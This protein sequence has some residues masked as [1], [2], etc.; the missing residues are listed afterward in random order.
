MSIKFSFANS[1]CLCPGAKVSLLLPKRPTPPSFT[2][3]PPPPPLPP[4]L[5]SPKAHGRSPGGG[6]RQKHGGSDGRDAIGEVL[7]GPILLK[8]LISVTGL[9]AQVCFSHPLLMS[10]D[11][12]T[13]L[14]VFVEELFPS[15][16]SKL[17]TNSDSF[18][19]AYSS[20]S[21]A[22]LRQRHSA[23]IRHGI[24]HRKQAGLA[25]AKSKEAPQQGSMS[26]TLHAVS[27]RVSK[28]DMSLLLRCAEV[29]DFVTVLVLCACRFSVE[30]GEYAQLPPS[31][32]CLVDGG[33]GDHRG[34]VSCAKQ[35]DSLE[36]LC[37]I[38]SLQSGRYD[39]TV[40]VQ[41]MY[42]LF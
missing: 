11:R 34:E 9:S 37:W 1:Q 21:L 17:A 4:S 7:C 5:A 23:V 18:S 27:G 35:C 29:P 31:L 40:H 22:T 6:S 41:Y 16:Y 12:N 26:V 36:I 15:N 24:L 13:T 14:L 28:A 25:L 42:A 10:L 2:S 19:R 8:P 33:G 39:C 38:A 20:P 32:Q 3:P 30:A